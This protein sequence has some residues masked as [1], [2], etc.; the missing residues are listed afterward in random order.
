[1]KIV[2]G[3]TAKGCFSDWFTA[4]GEFLCHAIEK[5][6]ENNAPFVSCIPEG[7]YELVEYDSPKFG[8]TWALVGDTVGL[9]QGDSDRYACLIH[10]ANWPHDVQGC[11]AP[12][13]H[14]T[15]LDGIWAGSSSAAAYA[16]V[17]IEIKNG[18]TT[19]EITH[20]VGK[21]T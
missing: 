12:V 4:K 3:Y 6:W 14:L 11:I 1:M 15:V 8:D 20:A 5:S 21:L 16:K 10:K 7:N 18:D 2:R 9:F 13:S 19:L 17:V